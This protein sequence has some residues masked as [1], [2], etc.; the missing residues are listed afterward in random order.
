MPLTLEHQKIQIWPIEQIQPYER[1]PRTHS[2]HQ[3]AQIAASILEFGWTNP[4]LVSAEGALIA[5]HGRLE[6][7]RRLGVERV[8]VIVL[9][10]LTPEQQRALIIADNKHALNAGWNMD[11]LRGELESIGDIHIS[12]DAIGFSEEEFAD[13]LSPAEFSP[14]PERY[15]L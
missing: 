5:G 8:P 11:L 3:V 9:P 2:E 13:L 10:H 15:W 7:A 6:A 4:L 14:V 12:L 1:N